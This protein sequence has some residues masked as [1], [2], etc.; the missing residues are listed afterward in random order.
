M[1]ALK[2]MFR[3]KTFWLNAIGTVAVLINATQGQIVSTET[4]AAILAALN[5]L[6]RF[7]TK[8]PLAEK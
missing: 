4:A 3:S 2:G 5:V 7:L 6:N 1:K 8:K